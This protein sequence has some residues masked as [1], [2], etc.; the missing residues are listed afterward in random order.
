MYGLD[1]REPIG[2]RGVRLQHHRGYT[3]RDWSTST[4][5]AQQRMHECMS[6]PSSHCYRHIGQPFSDFWHI[7]L[8]LKLV[9][10]SEL[11]SGLG[12]LQK[13]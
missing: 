6:Y 1:R 11:V 8:S 2:V 9:D 12:Y 5:I 4:T 7:V 10:A 13:T 3:D